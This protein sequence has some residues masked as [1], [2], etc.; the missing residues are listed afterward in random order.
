MYFTIRNYPRITFIVS[1]TATFGLSSSVSVASYLSPPLAYPNKVRVTRRL[2]KTPF[3]HTAVIQ[4]AKPCFANCKATGYDGISSS[5]DLLIRQFSEK[6][7][8]L[9]FTKNV[10]TIN[11]NQRNRGLNTSW[12]FN[13]MPGSAVMRYNRNVHLYPLKKR[14]FCIEVMQKTKLYQNKVEQFAK[15]G[16]A[17][18]KATRYPLHTRCIPKQSF[19]KATGMQ[20]VTQAT[21]VTPFLQ[22]VVYGNVHQLVVAGRNS[23]R[24][25][26]NQKL[27]CLYPTNLDKMSFLSSDLANLGLS[28]KSYTYLKQKGIH[29]IGNIVEYSPKSL[30]QLLN[31]NK[32]MFAELKRCFLLIA[33][34]GDV[35]VREF[36]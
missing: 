25:N 18:C 8:Q 2:A 20:R 36:T 12:Q 28:L 26:P 4:F 23:Y 7:K 34:Y 24:L 17:N 13:G 9:R 19:G 3:L 32:E 11:H 5:K 6:G 35:P 33:V 14:S 16:F 21:N 29:K 1:S 22:N 10:V 15:Q 27:G 30:L 31:R